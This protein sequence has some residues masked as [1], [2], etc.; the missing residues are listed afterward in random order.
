MLRINKDR[1][2][3]MKSLG[4]SVH[5]LNWDF[6]KEIP[7]HTCPN[8]EL[9]HQIILKT[10][11][12]YQKKLIEMKASEEEFT[13]DS[14]LYNPQVEIKA[15]TVEVFYQALIRELREKGRVGNSYAYLNSYNS[16]KAF[17]KGNKLNF[18]FSHINQNYLLKYEDWLRQRKIKET[19]LSY[20]FRTLRAAF[21]RAIEANAV[22]KSKNPFTAFKISKFSTK[23]QKRALSKDDILKIVN[24]DKSSC[25]PIR[26]LAIDIFTFSYLCGGISFVDITNL[27]STNIVEG[28]LMYHRQKTN[29]AINLRLCD[30]AINIMGKYNLGVDKRIYLFP[31]LNKK[32]HKTPMQRSNRVHK[33]C[34]QINKELKASALGL[35]IETNVTTYVARH[36]FA[37]ILKKSGVNIGIISEALGHQDIKTTEIYLS[38][39]DNSQVDSAMDNLL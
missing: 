17:N 24:Y 33:I 7:K 32:R 8:Y 1:K 19:T 15:I 28:R 39:F 9:I 14:L 23:T 27:E 37:T 25:S 18:T 13:S 36:S 26:E 34:Y 30:M 16:L 12:E 2:R 5:P 22:S 35:G 20:L 6:D 10:K 11:L 38:R 21:N 31:I 3:S 29:S 4:I